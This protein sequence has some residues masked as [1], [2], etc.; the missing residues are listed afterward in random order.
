MMEIFDDSLYYLVK[1][2][3]K[4][5]NGYKM[6]IKIMEHL[7][8]Q[9][10][11]D[12][13]RARKQFTNYVMDESLT[14]KLEHYKFSEIINT[15]EYA[16]K[17]KI[18]DIDKMDFLYTRLI[19]DKR[20]GLKEVMIQAK[21]DNYDYDKTI[22][23][24]IEINMDTPDSIKNVKLKTMTSEKKKY[25]FAFNSNDTCKF[26][27]SCRYIH[28][29]DPT[30]TNQN[31]SSNVPSIQSKKN[32]N[33]NSNDN[34]ESTPSKDV[35]RENRTSYE[36]NV[37]PPSGVKSDKNPQG[38]SLKQISA[39]KIIM[40][41]FSTDS[42]KSFSTNNV[43]INST[44]NPDID[45]SANFSSWGDTSSDVYHPPN[46]NENE[47]TMNDSESVSVKQENN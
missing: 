34:K 33:K 37:G 17:K 1:P 23:K 25:C 43:S 16:Q 8:G 41:H 35:T 18:D 39:R 30:S 3:I 44:N 31:Q 12:A 26:G 14:F 2:E 42:I 40:K 6:Y 19:L 13:E 20:I 28:E 32:S 29:M 45:S 9:R 36:P 4:E 27:A 46:N 24:L 11:K 38:W 5:K 22:E 47:I 7:N 21:L 10:A 15:L